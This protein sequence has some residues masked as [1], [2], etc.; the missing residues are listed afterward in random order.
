MKKFAGRVIPLVL[1]WVI[2]LISQAQTLNVK[3]TG[4]RG[5]SGNL[6]IAVFK[7]DY[8]YR[9]EKTFLKKCVAKSTLHNDSIMVNISLI[10]GTYCLTVHD[11]A[12]CNG[13]MKYDVL[14]I[15]RE[16]FGFSNFYLKRLKKPSFDEFS[17]TID[18]NDVT[19]INVRMKYY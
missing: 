18:Q 4:I 9:N 19:D 3:I 6:C 10:P 14:G 15:P 17:F 7:S 12:D 13:R 16:G 11:D 5:K 8:D 2:P 1:F